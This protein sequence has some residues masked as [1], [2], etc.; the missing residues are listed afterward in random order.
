VS[1]KQY[2]YLQMGY[3]HKTHC[4]DA[5]F[6][7]NLTAQR[8]VLA[9]MDGCT[10]GIESYFAATL[11][12]KLL[13]KITHQYYLRDFVEK[14]PKTLS[15]A[16]EEIWQ[17]LFQQLQALASNL[18]LTKLELL[19]TIMIAIVDVVTK[20]LS[21]LSVGDGVVVYNGIVI[22]YEQGNRPDYLAYHLT[23]NF[24]SWY[25]QQEQCL[26]LSNISDFSLSSDGIFSFEPFELKTN[27]SFTNR[28]CLDYLLIEQ[29]LTNTQA[30]EQRVRY[31]EEEGKRRPN[32]DLE[33]IRIC[34][35]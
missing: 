1:I 27:S 12:A 32:D 3:F 2:H 8:K 15:Q 6:I 30:L 33:I 26:Q 13:K 16:Q 18:Y 10:M 4:E 22:E 25:S 9:V 19:T 29:D 7:G 28:N 24:T 20:E 17:T 35:E 11:V 21:V 31:I 23:E 14:Q 34:Y 5:L